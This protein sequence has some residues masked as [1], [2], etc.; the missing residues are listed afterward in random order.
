MVSQG[1]NPSYAAPEN[2]KAPLAE[3]LLLVAIVRADQPE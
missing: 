3:R 2:E 1:L